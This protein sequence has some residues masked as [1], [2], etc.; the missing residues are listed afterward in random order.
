MRLLKKIWKMLEKRAKFAENWNFAKLSLYQLLQQKK[1]FAKM[2]DFRKIWL[3][4]SEML[5]I[6][7]PAI[8][9]FSKFFEK[10]H[11]KI[12]PFKASFTI[13]KEST[14]KLYTPWKLETTKKSWPNMENKKRLF[15]EKY[16][17]K[18][19]KIVLLLVSDLAERKCAYQNR[20]WFTKFQVFFWKKNSEKKQNKKK[21]YINLRSPTE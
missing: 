16:K 11:C 6:F 9:K 15:G 19:W 20:K 10:S 4:F 1:K 21:V 2:S 18:R 7:S 13:F 3:L 14:H 17:I 8:N 5:K 12:R